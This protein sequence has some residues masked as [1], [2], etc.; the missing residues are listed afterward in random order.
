[1]I[2]TGYFSS[3]F[4]LCVCV[5]QKDGYENHKNERMKER[6]KRNGSMGKTRAGNKIRNRING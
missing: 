2:F 6:K 3:F 5:G 1:M 4:F